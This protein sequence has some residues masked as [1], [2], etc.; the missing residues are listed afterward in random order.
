MAGAAIRSQ[1]LSSGLTAGWRTLSSWV[2]LP[3]LFTRR[4]I[5]PTASTSAGQLGGPTAPF[6][7]LS[8]S[9]ASAVEIA[10][11][12]ERLDL[13]GAGLSLG[14]VA[15]QALVGEVVQALDPQAR[16]VGLAVLRDTDSRCDGVCCADRGQLRAVVSHLLLRALCLELGPGHVRVMVTLSGRE[17]HVRVLSRTP[18]ATLAAHADAARHDLAAPQRLLQAMGGSLVLEPRRAGYLPLCIALP[19]LSAA[20]AQR[21]A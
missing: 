7:L 14:P 5:D 19:A 11:G 21:A 2:D 13:N 16:K 4:R 1:T 6:S 9:A 18:E 17:A 8:A 10:R 12:V 20:P 15:V 3:G